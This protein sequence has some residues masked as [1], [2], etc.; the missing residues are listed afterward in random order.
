MTRDG[1]CRRTPHRRAHLKQINGAKQSRARLAAINAETTKAKLESHQQSPQIRREKLELERKR[2][3]RQEEIIKELLESPAPEG[4]YS[5]Q[6][7]QNIALVAIKLALMNNQPGAAI[8]GATLIADLEGHLVRRADIGG[9]NEFANVRTQEDV[10]N[11][12][13]RTA[14]KQIA[15]IMRDI[16]DRY[17]RGDDEALVIEDQSGNEE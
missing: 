7:C 11:M 9:V 15:N 2:A 8:Q 17:E 16:V 5:K 1:A 3:Q 13:E 4:G 12:F 6:D 14:G 10:I